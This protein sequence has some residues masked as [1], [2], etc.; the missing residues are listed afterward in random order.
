MQLD[1]YSFFTYYASNFSTNQELLDY[2]I[3]KLSIIQSFINCTLLKLYILVKTM[4]EL[5][6]CNIIPFHGSLFHFFVTCS[7][8][9]IL[10]LLE[11]WLIEGIGYETQQSSLL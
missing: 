4:F 10:L 7:M 6:V 3:P 5:P 11:A 2:S 1:K 8:N 9:C